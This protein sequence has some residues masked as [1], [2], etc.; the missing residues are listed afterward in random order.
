MVAMTDDGALSTDALVGEL[1]DA[2]A[3]LGA[4][5]DKMQPDR[6]T[7]AGL[8]GEWSARELVG[9]LAYWSRWAVTCV[10][11]ARG[12]GLASLVTDQWDVDGQNAAVAERTRTMTM[13]AVRA[14]EVAA[15]DA[16]VDALAGIDAALLNAEAP[17]GG[18]LETIVRENGPN[19]YRVHAAQVLS[20]CAIQK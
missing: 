2:R 14:E 13:E 3:A 7:T 5:I 20:W 1:T 17:W 18:T 10:D 8:A 19:H 9:H 15:F 12:P 4:A 11:A 16:F 6:L